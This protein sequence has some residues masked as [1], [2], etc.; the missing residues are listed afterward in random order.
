MGLGVWT[1][2]ETEF[3]WKVSIEEIKEL[4]YNLD[5]KNPNKQ[6]DKFGDPKELLEMLKSV[7]IKAANLREELKISLMKALLK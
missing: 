1:R 6:V 7:E 5:I 4:D 2:E 3:A